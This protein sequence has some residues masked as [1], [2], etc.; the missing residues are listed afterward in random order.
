MG[1]I[2]DELAEKLFSDD[3]EKQLEAWEEITKAYEAGLPKNVT[4]VALQAAADAM[5]EARK[6]VNELLKEIKEERKAKEAEEKK[7]PGTES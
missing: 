3:K 1:K 7:K 2:P 5:K 4:K 6:K